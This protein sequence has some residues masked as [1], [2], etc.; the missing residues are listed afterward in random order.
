MDN[1]GA[2]PASGVDSSAEMKS[3][4]QNAT[5]E[6]RELLQ[7]RPP[8]VW[9]QPALNP[10]LEMVGEPQALNR[11]L[12]A[13]NSQVQSAQLLSTRKRLSDLHKRVRAL[14]QA[15]A[16]EFD[17]AKRRRLLLHK[18]QFLVR[19]ALLA[20]FATLLEGLEELDSQERPC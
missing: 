16:G 2:H 10:M 7:L 3:H 15:C 17:I 6:P 12:L 1:A 8:S 4:Q 19:N 20:A 13:L 9:V 14:T 11:T 18:T 5:A